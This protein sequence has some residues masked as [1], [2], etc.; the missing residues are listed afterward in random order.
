VLVLPILRISPPTYLL[1]MTAPSRKRIS[2]GADPQ[3]ALKIDAL[4]WRHKEPRPWFEPCGHPSVGKFY[5][6]IGRD[7]YDEIGIL[8]PNGMAP[9]TGES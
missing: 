1:V 9:F 4:P 2:S 3:S 6:G 7:E 8:V 5:E